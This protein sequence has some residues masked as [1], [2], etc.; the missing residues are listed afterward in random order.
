M[1]TLKEG[2]SNLVCLLIGMVKQL[3]ATNI[4]F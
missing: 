2:G 3:N 1:G 4:R